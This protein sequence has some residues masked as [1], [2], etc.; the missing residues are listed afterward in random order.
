MKY[1]VYVY[2]DPRPTKSQ[3][4]VYVGKG[5]GDRDM[6]HWLRESHNKPMQD[7]KSHLKRL[8]LVP[9]V[10]RVFE[11]DIESRAFDEEIRLIALYGRRNLRLGTL[12]N[13]TDGGEGGS[14][15]I[16]TAA[17]REVDRQ[18][19]LAHWR[20]PAYRAK[21]LAQQKVGN[22]TPEAKAKK[23]INSKALWE[24]DK[25]GMTEAVAASRRTPTARAK[26]AQQSAAQWADPAYRAK[27]E[28]IKQEISAR[29]EVIV[30]R[31]SK[32]KARWGDPEE[33]ERRRAAMRTA[34]RARY[35]PIHAMPEDRV[36]ESGTALK[37]ATGMVNSTMQIMLKGGVMK[38][39]RFEGWTLQ[40]VEP[41]I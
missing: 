18:I 26:T 17:H 21:V 30:A 36:Y 1:Y 13:L 22:A 20:D 38:Q 23:S 10:D 41:R 8:G 34:A 5:T 14:G 3:Q 19:S 11:T 15:T 9:I 37:A 35:K 31:S 25:T 12:F 39:G 32:L 29:P 24:G 2:R 4:P 27:M 28:A 7:F 16:R 40:Y 6:F 33:R